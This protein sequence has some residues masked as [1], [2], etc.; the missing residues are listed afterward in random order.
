MKQHDAISHGDECPECGGCVRWNESEEF[1][2]LVLQCDECGII[3]G[4]GKDAA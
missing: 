1:N 3:F 4:G 2:G